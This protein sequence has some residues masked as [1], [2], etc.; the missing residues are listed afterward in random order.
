M[1]V[2]TAGS[3]PSLVTG[4]T[5]AAA[6]VLSVVAGG[7]VGDAGWTSILGNSL[8]L[9]FR[10]IRERVRWRTRKEDLPWRKSRR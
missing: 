7:L 10:A 4:W 6:G 9:L 8:L 2:M 1:A 5:V 3:D